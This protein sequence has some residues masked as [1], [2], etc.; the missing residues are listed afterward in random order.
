MDEKRTSTPVCHNR[1]YLVLWMLLSGAPFVGATPAQAKPGAK[2]ASSQP[3]PLQILAGAMEPLQGDDPTL[4][5]EVV[6]V[7][8]G[9]TLVGR[10]RICVTTAGRV[11]SVKPV[12]SIAG[13]DQAIIAVLKSW[14]FQ[15]LPTDLC[16]TQTFTFEVQ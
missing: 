7:S 2:A 13:A 3:I 15:R 11:Y 6:A 14:K 10:Y 9:Q 8:R 5:D 4:P 16:Q 1:R 12:V